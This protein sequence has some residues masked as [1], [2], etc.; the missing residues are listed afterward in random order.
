MGFSEREVSDCWDFLNEKKALSLAT[1]NADGSNS[2]APLYYCADDLRNY[3]FISDAIVEHSLNIAER[4]NVS[5][6][7]YDEGETI[8]SIKGLQFR[9]VCQKLRNEDAE[10]AKE[11][12]L[13]RFPEIDAHSEMSMRFQTMT[14][15][16][17]KVNWMRWMVMGPE[18]PERHE[19]SWGS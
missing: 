5:G 3:Y 17:I 6:A 15:Y 18:G 9:G 19:Q 2:L 10:N 16:G 7:I 12:Y 13:N 1:S 4:P 11:L 14:I 8:L